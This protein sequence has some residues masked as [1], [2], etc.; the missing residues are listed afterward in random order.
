[1]ELPI[2]FLIPFAWIFAALGPREALKSNRNVRLW[3]AILA[4]MVVWFGGAVADLL[5]MSRTGGGDTPG[6]GWGGMGVLLHDLPIWLL[7]F[8]PSI[9]ALI[10]LATCY[11]RNSQK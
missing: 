11:P 6:A 2:L 10:S 1:M 9:P 4:L 8:G 7:F 5:I 3:L